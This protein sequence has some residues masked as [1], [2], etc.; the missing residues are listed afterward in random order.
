MFVWV[1]NLANFDFS[2]LRHFGCLDFETKLASET[3][4]V[5]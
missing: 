4:M 5:K 2:F 1:L 3:Y